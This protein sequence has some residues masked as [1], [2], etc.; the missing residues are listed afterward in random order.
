MLPTIANSMF[1]PYLHVFENTSV[2]DYLP[3]Y[4]LLQPFW[5]Y[6]RVHHQDTLRSPLFPVIISVSGYFFFSTLFM[7]LDLLAPKLPLLDKYRIHPEKP[8]SWSDISKTLGLTIYQNL[9]Y[10]FPVSVAQWYWRPPTQLPAAAPNLSE[11]LCGVVGCT[12]L[13]DFQYYIWHVV[14]HKIQWLYTTFHAIHHEYYVTFSWVAQYLSA[15]ELFTLGFWTTVNPLILQCHCLTT[16]AFMVFNVWI[17]VEDHSGYDFP[18][19]MHN[20]I[21]FQLWGGSIK[22]AM[23]HQ[24]PLTNFAPFFGHM[25]W[26]F[27]TGTDLKHSPAVQEKKIKGKDL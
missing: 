27:G 5:D 7:V 13:F 19:S 21:P 2:A 15:W 20:L 26:I 6:L 16:W 24:K 8:V 25:D 3:E 10:I 9:V 12:L 22:H 23:H 1:R 11:L 18:W 14:H 17:S 4:S